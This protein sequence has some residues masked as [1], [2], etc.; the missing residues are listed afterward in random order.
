V[1]LLL[2]SFLILQEDEPPPEPLSR[3]ASRVA[4]PLNPRDPAD[5]PYSIDVIERAD[6]DRR[7]VVSTPQA[8][9]Q[10]RGAAV[11]KASAGLAAPAVRGFGGSRLLFLVDGIRL[12]TALWREEA[13][14]LGVDSFLFERLELLRGP[15]GVAHGSDALGGVVLGRTREPDS[16]PD[17]F[18]L[19][20]RTLYRWSS[21][22]GSHTFRAETAALSS[23]GALFVGATRRDFDDLVGGRDVGE[24]PGT[25]SNATD[26]DAKVVANLGDGRSVVLA[27]QGSRR[28]GVS[29]IHRTA[30]SVPWEGAPA[31][32]D[33][34]H[35]LDFERDLIYLQFRWRDAGLVDDL[36]ASVSYHRQFEHLD[37]T[38]ASLARQSRDAEVRTGGFFAHAAKRTS[39]GTFT[40]GGEF[41]ADVVNSRGADMSPA[42]VVSTFD[43]G[44]VADDSVVDLAGLYVQDEVSIGSS[45]DLALGLR[46]TWSRVHS[47]DVD[48]LG[49]GAPPLEEFEQTYGAVTGNARVMFRADEYVRLI[50]GVSQGF[51]PP[52]LDDLT[53]IRT[54]LSGQTD[55]PNPGLD[56]ERWISL[57]LGARAHYEQMTAGL[58]LFWASL[59]GLIERRP[60]PSLGPGAFVKDNF[61][62]EVYG[63]EAFAEYRLAT[64]WVFWAD[65]TWSLGRLD[66]IVAGVERE[67]PLSRMNPAAMHFGVRWAPKGSTAF[68]EAL[69]AGARHQ[70]RLSPTDELD[71]TRIPPG[72]TPGY[73][74]VSLRGGLELLTNIRA[75][76][77][78]ENVV[79]RDARVHGSGINEAGTNFIFGLDVKF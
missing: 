28:P 44:E 72:G 23:T 30:R 6:L 19:R 31:G 24:M 78:V 12:N 71:V 22:E 58:L 42:G 73:V 77:A 1:A 3:P 25:S 59:D 79:D 47:I 66:S 43:R 62:G 60:E 5:V 2:L 34:R 29:R 16:F 33:L 41:Y 35:E 68:V 18:E 67:R 46:W 21:A 27:A 45:V 57:E 48:P 51:R 53:A 15:P 61:D 8:F 54:V 75:H 14:W 38:D 76:V 26:V 13:D 74:L 4:S 64:T 70:D 20:P 37:R 32:T 9:D 10:S 69:V 52:N 63:V 50:A 39:I 7:L 65:A 17:A 49:V 36:H 40:F 55:F 56:P 11:Q